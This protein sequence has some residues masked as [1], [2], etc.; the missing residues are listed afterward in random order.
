[1]GI[2]ESR[3]VKV[4]RDRIQRKVLLSLFYFKAINPPRMICVPILK[5]NSRG[6]IIPL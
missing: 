5:I 6:A 1:M 2:A 4:I 3:V